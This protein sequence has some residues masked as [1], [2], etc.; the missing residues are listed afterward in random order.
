MYNQ[1]LATRP[2]S[3]RKDSGQ[4]SGTA[5]AGKVP[6]VGVNKSDL[7]AQGAQHGWTARPLTHK[8]VLAMS[9]SEIRWHEQFNKQ[10][11][12][13]ALAEP[14]KIKAH[15]DIDSQWK[16]TKFWD[17][18]TGISVTPDE[19]ETL[20]AEFKKFIDHYPQYKTPLADENNDVIFGWLRDRHMA[21]I[22]SNLVLAFEANALEGKLWLNP[23]AISAGKESEVFG[24]DHHAFDLLVQPQRRNADDG[25]SADDFLQAHKDVLADKRVPPLIAAREAKAN[26]T[27]SYFYQTGT[28]TASS[29]STK[30]LDYPQLQY[31][32]PPQSEKYS[33][34]KLVDSMSSTELAQRCQRDP[35]FK[36][37]LDETK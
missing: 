30:V 35:A 19:Y 20:I 3:R 26:A 10:N 14:G 18:T 34:R 27:A 2:R 11:L 33:F 24:T 8:E 12:D 23:S 13:K 4:E 7:E 31:G 32:V 21:P 17:D 16:A 9:S 28:V 5:G 22:F 37:A 15:K 1:F 6:R 29:G 36:K 25:L